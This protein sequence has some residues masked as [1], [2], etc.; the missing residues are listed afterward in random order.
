MM[1]PKLI[2]FE[3]FGEASGELVPFYVNKSFPKKF[4]LKRFFFY[5]EKK[6]ILEQI[7]R[8]KNVHK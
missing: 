6:N 1:G 5:M 3:R 4:R 2:N 8:T 7:M